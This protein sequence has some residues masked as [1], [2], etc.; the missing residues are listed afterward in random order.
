MTVSL[1]LFEGQFS[2]FCWKEHAVLPYPQSLGCA[3]YVPRIT[4]ARKLI[5]NGT[6]LFGRNAILLNGWK[7][8]PSAVNNTRIDSKETFSCGLPNLFFPR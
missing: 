8:S 3:S 1:V 6:F 5:N 7:G 2:L 4:L